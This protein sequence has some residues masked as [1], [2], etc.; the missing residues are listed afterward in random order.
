MIFA[1]ISAY[2]SSIWTCFGIEQGKHCWKAFCL[3]GSP[4]ET[5]LTLGGARVRILVLLLRK[6]NGKGSVINACV[7][8]EFHFI[9]V[10]TRHNRRE[11]GF[12]TANEVVPNCFTSSIPIPHFTAVTNKCVDCVHTVPVQKVTKTTVMAPTPTLAS[13]LTPP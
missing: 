11:R 5:R 4:L 9:K 8:T 7:F 1:T 3:H 12:V 2:A 10:A 13:L 6:R